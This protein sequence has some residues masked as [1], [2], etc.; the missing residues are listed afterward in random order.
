MLAGFINAARLAS[1]A[2]GR[3]LQDHRI[4]F[5]GAGSAGVGVAKQLTAF[6]T[7]QGLSEEEAKKHIYV[8]GFR[9]QSHEMIS[10]YM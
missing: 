9:C 5:F 6:F 4:L 2:S 3:S 7:A 8:S 10:L 1:S